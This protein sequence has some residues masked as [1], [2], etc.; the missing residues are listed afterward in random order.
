M[1]PGRTLLLVLGVVLAAQVE[2]EDPPPLTYSAKPMR[3]FVLDGEKGEPLEGVAVVA[4]WVLFVSG[5]GHGGHGPRLHVAE[6]V[7]DNQGKF[8]IPGWGPKP[9]PGY[10]WTSLLDRDPMLSFFRRGYRPLTVQNRWERKDS[11]R[12]SEWDGK[13]INLEKFKGA[14]EEWAREVSFLQTFLGWLSKDMDW[15]WMPRM[16]LALELERQRLDQLQPGIAGSGFGPSPLS[17]LGT[18]VE[19]VRRFLEPRK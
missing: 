10:P 6:A 4:Q 1:G 3:G 11:V 16:V 13:T 7:T 2:V 12:F 18:T 17:S 8:L 19:E 15:R 14:A 5:P 9:N